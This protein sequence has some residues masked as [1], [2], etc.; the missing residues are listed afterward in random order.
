VNV[1]G[2]QKNSFFIR[3]TPAVHYNYKTTTKKEKC[4]RNPVF[5]PGKIFVTGVLRRQGPEG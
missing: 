5:A 3:G 4:K 2:H 1:P